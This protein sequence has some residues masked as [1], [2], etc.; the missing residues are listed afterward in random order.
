MPGPKPVATMLHNGHALVTVEAGEEWDADNE[1]WC[2]LRKAVCEYCAME[3]LPARSSKGAIQKF[4]RQ[5][6]FVPCTPAEKSPSKPR[7]KK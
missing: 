1:L 5:H 2:K 3:G 4:Q 6:P 7:K